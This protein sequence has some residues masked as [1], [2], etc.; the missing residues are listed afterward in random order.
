MSSSSLDALV[1]AYRHGQ[2]DRRSFIRSATATGVTLGVATSL[3]TLHGNTAHASA[4]TAV[5]A[6]A[7]AY[8]FIVVGSGSAGAALAHRLATTS[9]ARVLVLEAGGPDDIPEIHDPRQWGAALGTAA[10]KWFQTTPQPHTLDRIHNWPR[11]HV[12]GGTSALNAMVFARGHRSDFDHWAYEGN[13]GWDYASVLPHFKAFEDYEG[14]ASELRG[15][16][17]PLHVS[18]PQPGKRHPGAEAFMAA[19]ADMG[20]PETPSI[21]GPVM[22]GP[23][24]V[25]LTIKD[26]RRQSTAV[27]FLKPAMA[28]P[29]L[30]VLTDAP[31][32]SLTFDGSRCTGVNY[33]HGG[34]LRSVRAEQEVILAAGAID[35]PRLL[36]L[37]GIGPA[38]ELGPLGITPV[39][40]LAGVGR[41]MQDHVLGGGPN[42]VAPHA[43]PVSEYNHS[44]VYMWWRSDARLIAPDVIV[45]YVSVPFATDAFELAGG[46][47]GWCMLSGLAR[48]SSRGSLRLASADFADPPIVDPNYLATE[49]DRRAFAYATELARELALHPAYADQRARE[50]LPG[51]DVQVGTPAWDEFVKKSA[52]T[53]FHPTSTCRMGI[54]QM[55]VVDPSLRVY[56][57]E[58][59]RVADAS[60]MPSITTSNTNAPSIMI[61]WKAAELIRERR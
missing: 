8:D 6:I 21:N 15:S 3:A 23:A 25:D 1:E 24:W 9:D 20:F 52:H 28:R 39:V 12:L 50:V 26:Q 22:E 56:G 44:E 34:D 42:Y 31:V 45:L 18:K 49:Q 5:D 29:N 16:G 33:L 32:T 41:N 4:T 59:L 53:Y 11:G 30:T 46:E 38:D 57:I 17:G 36:L 13:A 2:L 54:D 48:P 51:A 35:S 43:L 27:A 61:G 60:V 58:G 37:S 40:D 14:G 47:H 19:A 10:T 7:P 55:A